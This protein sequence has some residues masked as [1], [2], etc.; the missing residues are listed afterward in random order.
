MEKDIKVHAEPREDVKR[1]NSPTDALMSTSCL[2]MYKS[3]TLP[4]K[5]AFRVKQVLR[6]RDSY[7]ERV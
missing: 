7:I 4:Q 6:P 3:L 1:S 5:F 2:D